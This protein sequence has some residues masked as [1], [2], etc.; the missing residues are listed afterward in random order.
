MIA[1]DDEALIERE[2]ERKKNCLQRIVQC[3]NIIFE[4]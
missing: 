4:M 3:L 1:S 2:D